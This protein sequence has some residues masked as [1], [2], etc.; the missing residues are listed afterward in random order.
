MDGRQGA[1]RRSRTGSDRIIEAAE[2][3]IS[4]QLATSAFDALNRGDPEASSKFARAIA[5]DPGNGALIIGEAEALMMAGAAD[6]T[7]RLRATV[8]RNPGWV[9][10]QRALA[11]LSWELDP[12]QDCVE[13]F[14]KALQ[15][16]PRNAAL[17]N[18]YLQTLTGIEDYAGAAAAAAAAR[19]EFDDPRLSRHQA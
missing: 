12:K 7:G 5:A 11:S 2:R 10:G 15:D 16:D 3:E 13:L 18:A 17:W 4:G 6:P 8:I 19:P 1:A 14:R 9:D